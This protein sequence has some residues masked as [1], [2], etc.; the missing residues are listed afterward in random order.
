MAALL[1]AAVTLS[2][3][4]LPATA[5]AQ[6]TCRPS[7]LGAVACPAPARPKPRPPSLGAPPT[8]ALDR[9]RAG[10]AP[11]PTAD[12]IPARRTRGLGTVITNGTP[13]PSR[14]RADTLGNL[15]CR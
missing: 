7:A 1:A 13:G 5:A 11:A 3:L 9:V 8:Q 15:R 14:C 10:D 12:F 6:V 2:A 4:T